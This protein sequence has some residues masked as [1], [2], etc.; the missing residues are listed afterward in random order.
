MT[1]F[2]L[3]TLLFTFSLGYGQITKNVFFVGNSYIHTNDLPQ[4][5]A[6]VATSTGDQLVHQSHTPGGST[7]QQHANNTN[8]TATIS[9]GNWDYV[10]LQEQSQTPAFPNNYVNAYMF[11]FAAQLSTLVKNENPCG[12]PIFFMTWGY[13]NGDATNC[14]GGLTNMCTYQGMDDTIYNRYMQMATNNEALVSPVGRV[15]K[16]IRE[17]HPQ[18]ELYSPDNSH[19]SYLGSMAAAYTFYTVIFKKNPVLATFNGTLSSADAQILKNIVKTVVF[20]Q[21][22]T[23][24]INANDVHSSFTYSAVQNQP[25]NIQFT[26]QTANATTYL[27]NFGDGSTSTLQNPTHTFAAPGTYNVSLTTNA[28]TTNQT[29][30]KILQL[31]ALSTQETDVKTVKIYPNPVSEILYIDSKYN[32]ENIELLDMVGRKIDVE[33]K[34]EGERISVSLQHLSKGFYMLQFTLKGKIYQHKIHKK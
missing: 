31:Q 2:L 8:V 22:D 13:K 27:W 20:D 10:V 4:L 28:C 30:T 15:W 5:I 7:L 14:N 24:L 26:N 19:P 25:L 12:N 3:F 21:M 34:N 33:A 29:K 32:V 1:K 23:W 16:A 18:L 6:Q 9:Q 17:Q 11:P